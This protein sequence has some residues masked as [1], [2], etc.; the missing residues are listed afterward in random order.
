MDHVR[1]QVDIPEG[2]V[3]VVARAAEHHIPVLDLARE[4]HTIVVEQQKGVLQEGEFFKIESVANG[5]TMIAIAPCYIITI[6]KP[7]D[8]RVITILEPADLGVITFPE[9]GMMLRGMMGFASYRQTTSQVSAGR[10]C[11]AML[12]WALF[13]M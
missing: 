8:P 9:E 4:Q 5:S 1:A 11:Q 6:F 2:S 7:Y 3:A 10:S 13:V 12:G